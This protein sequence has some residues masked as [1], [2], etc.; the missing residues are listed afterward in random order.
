MI[1]VVFAP[2]CYGTVGIA[3]H[4]PATIRLNPATQTFL[5]GTAHPH[6]PNYAFLA[7]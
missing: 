6:F 1:D 3:R 2:I 5:L 7:Q 4:L